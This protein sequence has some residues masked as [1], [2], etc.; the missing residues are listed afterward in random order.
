MAFVDAE[1]HISPVA[2]PTWTNCS[3]WASSVSI[4][5]GERAV[6]DVHTMDGDVPIR[7]AGKRAGLTLTGRFAYTEEAD[8]PFDVL[9]TQYQTP[10]S[11]LE[12]QF[13]PKDADGKWYQTGAAILQN[14]SYPGGE[15]GPGGAIMCEFVVAVT[16]LTQADSSE[17]DG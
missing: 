12:V 2:T 1:L 5:G 17:A 8:H 16:E 11:Y 6:D 7:K 4:S 13:C 10:G 9:H 14:V 3:G 15:V